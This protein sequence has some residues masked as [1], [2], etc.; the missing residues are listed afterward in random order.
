MVKGLTKFSLF[1]SFLFIKCYFP[2]KEPRVKHNFLHLNIIL[3]CIILRIGKEKVIWGIRSYL[4]WL[5]LLYRY[6]RF[7][8]G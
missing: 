8:A 1:Q 3:C 6:C 2:S 4:L 7:C 5:Y